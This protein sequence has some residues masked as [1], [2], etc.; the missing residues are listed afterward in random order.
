MNDVRI[1]RI[2]WAPLNGRRA[3]AARGNAYA[4]NHGQEYSI[5]IARVAT[6]DGLTAFGWSRI[7]RQTA[8]TLVGRP[9][10]DAF[11]PDGGVS[12]EFLPLDMALWD[13][14]GKL[15]DKPAYELLS[16]QTNT[17]AFRAPCYDT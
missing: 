5:S 6:G 16:G 7:D 1:D 8:E 10:R 11:H 14:A 17:T 4:R 12:T 15:A 13:L 2:E 3:R 9:F